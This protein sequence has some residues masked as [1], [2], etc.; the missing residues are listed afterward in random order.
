MN[1]NSIIDFDSEY[2][3]WFNSTYYHMLYEDRGYNEA[4]KF[5]HTIL[6]HLKLDKNSKILDA[7]CGKGRHSIE[8]EKL[9]YNVTG[10]DLSKNSINEAKKY[11]NINLKFLI[12]DISIPLKSKFDAVFNLFTSFGYHNK[13]K[14]LDVLN[15]IEKNLKN[16]GI[17]VIDFFNI[18]KIKKD[19]IKEEVIIKNK[20]KFNIKRKIYNNSV[21]KS[22]SF[23]DNYKKHLF[24]ENVNALSLNNFIEYFSKTNL[25]IQQVF[26]SYEL[27]KF[28]PN[29][30][31]R[32]IIIFKK[33]SQPNK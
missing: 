29:V 9:G 32:L 15:A 7:A 13:K 5:V 33:K 3:T 26:G 8:I 18:I 1:K 19:L 12:H 30:S 17:G 4:K 10:I 28:E 25:E 31:P 22:I 11:E 16:D 6:N 21:S 23:E 2:N 20:I 24:N 14:D 27:S